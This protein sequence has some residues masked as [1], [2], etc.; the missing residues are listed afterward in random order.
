MQRPKEIL[1]QAI[2]SLGN[3]FGKPEEIAHKPLFY[4]DSVSNN[5]MLIKNLDNS[6]LR[7]E[8][9][10]SKYRFLYAGG[11]TENGAFKEIVSQDFDM[12]P[13]Y[14]GIFAIKRLYQFG[15]CTR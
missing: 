4:L 14:I 12:K 15:Q 9:H 3:G 5:P 6:A 1:I 10:G 8:K 2:T 13:K 11:V 7:I